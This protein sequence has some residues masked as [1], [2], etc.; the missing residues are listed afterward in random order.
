M[1]KG[2]GSGRDQRRGLDKPSKTLYNLTYTRKKIIIMFRRK[3]IEQ[4]IPTNPVSYPS[5]TCVRTE[6]GYFYIKGLKRYKIP[7]ERVLSSWSFPRVLPAHERNLAKYK[8]VG[9]VGFREGTLIANVAD[10][11]LYIISG[12]RKCQIVNPDWLRILGVTKDDFLIVSE[13]EA[14]FHADGEV[15]D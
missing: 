8:Y 14:R 5:G 13:K 1:S 6:K 4:D 15:L 7:S 10:G 12:S 2:S 3:K 11:K 9:A